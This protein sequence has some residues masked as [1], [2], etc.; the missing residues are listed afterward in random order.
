[1]KYGRLFRN[2]IEDFAHTPST[3]RCSTLPYKELKLMAKNMYHIIKNDIVLD[4]IDRNPLINYQR[5]NQNE[6][7]VSVYEALNLMY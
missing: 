2:Y 5:M 1:M 3:N 4:D 7:A 6:L